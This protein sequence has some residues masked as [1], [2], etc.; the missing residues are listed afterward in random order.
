MRR[1]IIDEK[2]TCD[3]EVREIFPTLDDGIFTIYREF[4]DISRKVTL[5]FLLP[6]NFSHGLLASRAPRH[7]R[8]LRTCVLRYVNPNGGENAGE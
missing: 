3:A 1:E 2:G 6:R 7:L 5:G 4:Y 8:S